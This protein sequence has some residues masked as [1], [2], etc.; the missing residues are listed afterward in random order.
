MTEELPLSTPKKTHVVQVDPNSVRISELN[1]RAGTKHDIESISRLADEIKAAGQINDA[2]GETSTDGVIEVFAG[3]RR[4]EACRLAGLPL[5]IRV[6]SEISRSAAISIAYRDDREALTPSFW[7]L[8]GG[9]LRLTALREFKSDTELA[10]TVGIDKSTLSRGLAFRKAPDVILNAFA[11]RREI[12]LSQWI[13]LA[14]L[15]ENPETLSRLIERAGLIAGKDYAAP[16]VAAEFKAAAAGK[17]AL[18][19]IEVRNR[20]DRV[21][22][23]I[24]PDHRGG[25]TIKLKPL[26]ELHSTHRLDHVRL[27]HERLVEFVKNSFG[28]DA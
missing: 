28:R 4:C 17:I 20:H 19:I 6:H 21:V 3:S 15:V 26:K 25:C 9:W 16:R 5:R 24:Q 2:H 22:A 8:A 1:P 13:D 14:P 12:S 18:K 27:V 23:T 10:H 11:D 7:D